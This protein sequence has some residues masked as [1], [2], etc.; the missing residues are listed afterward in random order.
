MHS[1]SG[2]IKLTPHNDANDVIDKLFKSLR[3]IYQEN[4]ETSMKENYFIFDSVQLLYHKYHKV[5][6][7]RGDS[8]IDS[9]DWIK[10]KK[11]TINPKNRDDECFQYAA[12][13]ALNYEEIESYPERVSNIKSFMNKYNW[14]EINYPSK[15]EDWETFEKSNPTIALN[16]LYI[17]EKQTY[18]AYISKIDS[19]CEK[20]VILLMVPNKEK[21]GLWHYLVV[22]KLSTLVREITSKHHGAFYCLNCLHSFRAENKLKSHEKVHKSKDFC[23]ILIPSERNKILEFN[24]YMKSNKKPYI[25]YADIESLIRKI[26]WWVNNLEKSSTTKIGEHIP[27][28]YSMSIIWGFDHLENKHTLY[29][30][31][32]CMKKFYTCLREHAKNTID[33]DKKKCYR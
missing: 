28:G 9:P 6:F 18:P 25:I 31:K 3:S 15:T 4:L 27:Y 11:A 12:T 30:G 33:F 26:D 22:K 10:K 23:G 8:Y 14:D 16:I 20:H 7:D 21:E 32:D 24:Q 29:R 1:N 17:K 19:N 13:V 5:N 2:N